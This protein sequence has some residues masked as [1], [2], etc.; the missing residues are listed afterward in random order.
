MRRQRK[1]VKMKIS[2][3]RRQVWYAGWLDEDG[4]FV[5]YL[6]DWA[7]TRKGAMAVLKDVAPRCRDRT[8]RVEKVK[9]SLVKKG[10]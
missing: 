2:K 7:R 8:W 10:G 3:E 1:E 5:P 6:Q 9:L 4:D